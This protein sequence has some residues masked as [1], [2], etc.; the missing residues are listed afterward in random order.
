[1]AQYKNRVL[2]FALMVLGLDW[3]QLDSSHQ[4][5]LLIE[6]GTWLGLELSIKHVHLHV[7]LLL[8]DQL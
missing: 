2:L 4:R 8:L 7:C 1:M 5:S 6:V 3:A